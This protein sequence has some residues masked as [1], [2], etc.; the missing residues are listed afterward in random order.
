MTAAEIGYMQLRDDELEKWMDKCVFRK[1]KIRA[2]FFGSG[3][4]PT[5]NFRTWEE[6]QAAME[7]ALFA[8]VAEG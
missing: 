1:Q 2:K 6:E 7:K 3:Y 5:A 8:A 4:E